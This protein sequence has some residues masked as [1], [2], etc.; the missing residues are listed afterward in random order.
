[1]E[2]QTFLGQVQHRAQLATLEDAVTASRATLETLSERLDGGAPDNLAAQLPREIGR[3]LLGD[4]AG[5]GRAM[6]L[7]EFYDE[8]SLREGANIPT[9]KFHAK[10]VMSVVC[11]AVSPG[12]I[13]KI[14][15]QLPPDYADLFA[16]QDFRRMA[17]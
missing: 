2:Y 16:D 9:A 17:A 1:M 12:E 13:T 11:D 14:R 5:C 3:F 15:A 4:L 8:V 10:A 7:S 6:S